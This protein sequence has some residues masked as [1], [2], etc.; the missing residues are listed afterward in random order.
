MLNRAF[1]KREKVLLLVLVMILLGLV[2]YRFVRLPVQERIAAADTT[3]LEQQMEMEQQKSAIIKQMQ[4][5]IENGQK[6]VNGIVASYDNLKAESAALNTIFDFSFEQPVA[7]DD[8]VRRTINISFTATNYQ[9]ARRIIQQVHDCAYRC[10]ITDISVSADSDKMQQYANLEN[11]TISGS[12]SVTFYET[13]NGATTTNGLTTSD[14]SAVQSSNVGLGNASL[15]LAQSSLETMA[16]SL[17]GD[18]A[19]KI[20]AG[21]GF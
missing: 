13:L 15:D 16:E 1:T 14:G 12:M 21:A 2:Y 17:A 20:A 9:I 10:L 3:V 4:E 18:A 8:A 5:D 11:S 6:E 7:T 19:D